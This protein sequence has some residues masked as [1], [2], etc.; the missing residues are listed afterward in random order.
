MAVHATPGSDVGD[1][2]G[3]RDDDGDAATRVSET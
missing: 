1:D 3:E 2:S